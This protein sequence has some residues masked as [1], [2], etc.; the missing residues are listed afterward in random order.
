MSPT[1]TGWKRQKK[2][3]WTVRFG[4]V[5]SRA[6]ITV[7][8]IG[9]IIAV[10][11][12]CVFLVWVVAPLW[13]GAEITDP[14]FA[15]SPVDARPVHLAMDEYQLI[16]WILLADGELV[17]FRLTD[18]TVM[19]RRP[20]FTDRQATAFSFTVDDDSVAVGFAD[21]TVAFGHI[22][23]RASFLDAADAD[24]SWQELA[25]GET[26]PLADGIA[27]RISSAQFRVQRLVPEFD[28]VLPGASTTP[29]LRL[30]HVDS[31]RERVMAV[32]HADGTVALER[33][34]QRQNLLTRKVTY[35]K[36]ESILPVDGRAG[37]PAP[38]FMVLAGMGDTVCLA[39]SDGILLR[40]D[41]RDFAAPRLA[42]EIRLGIG[43]GATLTAMTSLLG[44]STILT[45]DSAGRVRAWFPARPEGQGESRL[46]AAHEFPGKGP[47]VTG[48]A[49]SARIR[50]IAVGHADGTVALHHVTSGKLLREVSLGPPDQPVLQLCFA[51]KDDGVMALGHS[52][53]GH[54]TMNRHHPEITVSALFRPV[55]YEGAAGPE[56]VW[57]SSSGT[58]DFEPKY[59][60]L[61]LIFGTLKATLFSMAFGLPIAL[62]A[63][64]F[65]SE[66]LPPATKAQVKPLVELMASLPSVVLGFLAALV[67]APVVAGRLAML[68]ALFMTLPAAFLG[69]A[70]GW[71]MLPRHRALRLQSWR[72]A[73]MFLA[74]PVGILAALA[75]GPV[76]ERIC[77]AGN[78]MEWLDGQAGR[79]AGGW[80]VLLLPTTALLAAFLS[81]RL[82]LPWFR[83]ISMA[84]SYEHCAAVDALRMLLTA[85]AVLAAA[86]A[87]AFALDLLG[88]DPRGSIF[89]RY[90]QRNA[91]VVGF[92]M[93]FAI[94]PIIYTIAEDALSAVPEHLRSASLGA[95]ATPWQTATRIIVPTA[96]S[97]LFS[98]VM[99]GLGRAVG[100]TMIVLMAAGN[101]PV[102]EL[103]VFNGFR[104][105]S[106]NIAVELPEAVR[107]ST[108]YRTL[109]LAALTL[110][111]MTFILN[112]VAEIVR[113]RFRKKAVEL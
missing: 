26:L 61:P 30:D 58:D 111:V 17:S 72:F 18:G 14:A 42:E 83:Q 4:D 74:L 28:A 79:A 81:G 57:Q 71:Q 45:G 106:A 39:W 12:V 36:E 95:G 84:W 1:A 20:L 29:V 80:F 2:T 65:T 103:N 33:I 102:M 91:L 99:I 73:F 8:G 53:I 100:E 50:A 92:V 9:T 49:S 13:R 64:I 38:D 32:A 113:I 59:G 108:H 98:A 104:T 35:S 7:G 109:F 69:G 16:G 105:L 22:R 23:F 10:F 86:V 94:I 3:G 41:S 96:M 19:D 24:A 37:R 70:Y 56:H 78:I 93:G 87:G 40:Y 47:A 34:S 21:G 66:F 48:I 110:F 43:P 62:L 60:M 27:Q 31:S 90:D 5:L 46:T 68:L 63:A 15:A 85:L 112:T 55:W 76:L 107:N 11:T 44:R 82:V 88:L 101:T 52:L 75:L 51:P 25:V 67:F 77:F 54:W 6:V 97:G 89:G